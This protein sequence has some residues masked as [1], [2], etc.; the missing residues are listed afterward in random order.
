MGSGEANA[1]QQNYKCKRS[2][3]IIS[4]LIEAEVI[5]LVIIIV[6]IYTGAEMMPNTCTMQHV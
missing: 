4:I 1:H 6:I 5:L 3:V 2:L